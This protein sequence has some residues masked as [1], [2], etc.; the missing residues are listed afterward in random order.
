MNDC[1]IMK[2][3]VLNSSRRWWWHETRM[4]PSTHEI[5]AVF[6]V[7]PTT[8]IWF[9][10]S[11]CRR[12]FR[13]CAFARHIWSWKLDCVISNCSNHVAFSFL[14]SIFEI[15]NAIQTFWLHVFESHLETKS[16]WNWLTH[17]HKSDSRLCSHLNCLKVVRA[18]SFING[19]HTNT[20]PYIDTQNTWGVLGD[21]ER[22][23]FEF[24]HWIYVH[25]KTLSKDR[26]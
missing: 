11:L 12:I 6:A 3:I 5:L 7:T 22:I 4:A 25:T 13:L 9:N 18:H 15:Q 2:K 21:A 8:H 19:K 10:Y 1:A 14:F 16:E 23:A 20:R 24:K 26:N 17:T